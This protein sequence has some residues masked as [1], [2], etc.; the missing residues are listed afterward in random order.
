[1]L[2]IQLSKDAKVLIL[3]EPTRGLDSKSKARLKLA[4]AELRDLGHAILIATH[5]EAFLADLTAVVLEIDNGRIA[6]GSL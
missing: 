1:V 4:L 6:G 5:D 2:A 3:D